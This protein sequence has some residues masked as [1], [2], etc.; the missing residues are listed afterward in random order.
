MVFSILRRDVSK[1]FLKFCLVG[2]ESTILNYL[3]FL[4][5]FIF[6]GIHYLVAGGLGFISG[7]IPGYIFNKIYSFESDRK[8][9]I[10]FPIYLGVYTF[11]L[12]FTIVSLKFLVD[13]IGI[14]PLISNPIT[15]IMTTVLNFFGTK[16]LAFQNKKW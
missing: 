5:L 14:N 11:S 13:Y 6:L 1:Q 7:T 2:L 4:V 8:N 12:V 15:I 16:I 3:V 9:V 10:A